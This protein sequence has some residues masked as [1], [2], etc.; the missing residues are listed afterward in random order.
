MRILFLF[1]FTG[2]S[3]GQQLHRQMLSANGQSATT[4]QGVKVSQ[5][6]GQQ[7]T[8]GTAVHGA[9]IV[10]QGFQ[11]GKSAIAA[12]KPLPENK[13]TV[14]PNPFNDQVNFRMTHPVEGKILVSLFDVQGR[15]LMHQEKEAQ[16]Q[17]LAISNLNL[18]AGEYFVK[19]EGSNY[20]YSTAILKSK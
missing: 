9:M 19:L 16:D 12:V 17:L 4:S 1:F 18:P 2:I 7:S 5:T 6:I 15:L 13:T 10:S 14:Y 3:F 8:T 11:Q 20:V